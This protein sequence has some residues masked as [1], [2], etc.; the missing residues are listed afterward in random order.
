MV[1]VRGLASTK[2]LPSIDAVLFSLL[3][4]GL[5]VNA[6]P[7]AHSS[8][9][10]QFEPLLKFAV[11]PEVRVKLVR[12]LPPAED[13]Q[14]PD[15]F[16][17]DAAPAYVNTGNLEEFLRQLFFTWS[18]FRRK[19][20]RLLKS[21]DI[22][23]RDQRRMTEGLGL[24]EEKDLPRVKLLYAALKALNLVTT[25]EGRVEAADSHAV[26]LFWNTS[27]VGQMRELIN[28]YPQLDLPVTYNI[29]PLSE[30]SYYGGLQTQPDAEI[31]RAILSVLPQ[32]S[33]A[34]WI[35]Y[36]LFYAFATSGVSGYLALSSPALQLLFNNMRWYGLNRTEELQSQFYLVEKEIVRSVL[37][38]MLMLGF[39]DIG[40][41]QQPNAPPEAVRIS[42]LLH[43]H[44]TQQPWTQPQVQGQVVLQPDAQ[45]LAI[46]PVPLRVLANLE[47]VA[48]REK[49][50]QGVITYRI[51]RESIYQAF[52]HG[53]TLAEIKG[54]LEDA[55]GQPL[56]QNIARSLEEWTDQHQR[57]LVRRDIQILQ[58]ASSETLGRLLDDPV[59]ARYLHRL[60]EKTAWIKMKDSP[61]VEERLRALEILP[62]H[63]MDHAKDL[64][65]SLRWDGEYLVSRTPLPSLYVIGTMQL[66]A[67]TAK[68]HQS[69]FNWALTPESVRD[70][71]TSGW[72]LVDILKTVETMTGQSLSQEWEKKLKAWGKY[73]GDG[74]TAQVRLVRLSSKQTL[75]E[76]R[77]KDRNLSRWLKP[78]PHSE[79]L[80]VVKETHWEETLAL[81]SSYGILIKDEVW[82]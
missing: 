28:A 36:P 43:A 21:G 14:L 58:V 35:P 55:T 24:S 7:L 64:V 45:L 27:P 54:Y 67:E 46:G 79:A 32:L 63:S 2:A 60:D 82:W 29:H 8:D 57:I 49:Q 61:I 25:S 26:T 3:S 59:V 62:S 48:V 23:K 17:A 80:A 56:P 5:I 38:E 81:L 75:H 76:L 20:A 33:S 22:G 6:T 72:K 41:G 77:S 44:L 66:I 9:R 37:K 13:I 30:F 16:G 52:Q 12:I 11:T 19:P 53:E 34:L 68:A 65:N 39:V 1:S 73:Y 47:R 70:A 42:E 71:V 10:R 51:T 4:K 74:N 69:F 31:R 15:K 18:E 40:Y 50:D 78:L